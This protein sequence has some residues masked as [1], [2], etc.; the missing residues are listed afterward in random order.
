MKVRNLNNEIVDW[1]VSA[2]D[3][4]SNKSGPHV[5]AREL[6]KELFPTS[7]VLEEV[8]INPRRGE[9]LY[10]DFYLP[11]QNKCIE[12]H[13]Q[14]HYNFTPHFHGNMMGFIKHKKRD[15]DKRDWCELNGIMYIEL[16]FDKETE[17]KTLIQ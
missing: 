7:Q 14:Q 4:T 6:I 5:V 16:P 9:T 15:R 13:G 8:P 12:V 3:V 2:S 11:L 17:W 10:L 1:K